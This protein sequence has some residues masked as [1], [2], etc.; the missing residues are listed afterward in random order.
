MIVLASA[1]PR[2]RELLAGMGFDFKIITSD[3]EEISKETDPGRIVEDLSAKKAAAVLEKIKAEG[4]LSEDRGEPLLIIAADTLVFFKDEILG[5]PVDKADAVRMIGELQGN[6]HSV[7]TGVT[8]ILVTGKETKQVSFHE[9]TVVSFDKMND[10]EIEAYV[11]TGEPMDKAGGYGIQGTC[12][13]FIRGIEGDYFNVVGFPVSH[14]YRAM[15]EIGYI[16]V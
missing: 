14:V 3:A 9:K 6:S 10:S 13:K 15:K 16:K 11:A 7:R 8:L 4:G 2:R 5:K 1:S 12:S